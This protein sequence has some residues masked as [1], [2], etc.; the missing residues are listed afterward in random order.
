MK[1]YI[2]GTGYQAN[3]Q[4]KE[5]IY[6]ECD[7]IGFIDSYKDKETFF[8]YPVFLPEQIEDDYDYIIISL[9]NPVEVISRCRQMGIDDSRLIVIYNCKWNNMMYM[10]HDM[11]K[12]K[13]AMPSVYNE[14]VRI[15]ELNMVYDPTLY[16]CNYDQIDEDRLI[17]TG[18]YSGEYSREYIRYRTFEL[19]A[20]EL[21]RLP[22]QN[23]NVAELGV[24][25]G[26]FSS[27]INSK[28]NDRLLYMFDT[29]EGFDSEEAQREM[30]MGNCDKEFIRYFSQNNVD[31]VI[32]NMRFKDKCV[33]RKGLF[34]STAS[35]LENERFGF[36]S[37][38]VDFGE[39][40]LAGLE[41]FYPRLIENGYIFIHDYN[42]LSLA[43]VKEAVRTY[44]E[45]NNITLK[46]VPIPDSNGTLIIVK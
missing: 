4:V 19:V 5:G 32:K 28:F 41:W 34:P 10:N 33:I 12:I 36:V 38:D 1:V 14:I 29:F 27:L 20:K 22:D 11:D 44:E 9:E 17:G 16:T 46:K 13:E 21:K 3:R 8:D 18:A 45:K 31:T 42:H 2:W 40:T 15:G 26:A 43:G 7:I 30:S 35:G 37:L 24:F 23:W 6:K 25:R 39:S